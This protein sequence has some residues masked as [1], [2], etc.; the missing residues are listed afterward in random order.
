[1][2]NKTKTN[3]IEKEFDTVKTFGEIKEKVSKEIIDM[4]IEHIKEYLKKRKVRLDK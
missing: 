1:L 3:K 4:D 2:A